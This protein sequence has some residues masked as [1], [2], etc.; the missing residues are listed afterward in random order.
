MIYILEGP[1]GTGKS[2]LAGEISKQKDATVVHPYFN[3]KWDMA[4]YHTAFIHFAEE[5]HDAGI[6]VVLDRWTPSEEVY[7][8][9]F[10]GGA[11]YDTDKMIQYYYK[12]LNLPIVFVYCRNDKAVENH[13]KNMEERD[14][15]FDDMSNIV[16]G[17]DNYVEERPW[18]N[19]KHYDFDKVDMERFVK[20]LP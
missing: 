5:C 12:V 6:P 10:R 17:F 8:R 20:E 15:M 2:T 16:V 7:A 14:E 19:W 1:D 18:M 13:L 11:A 9:V 4:S 3:K